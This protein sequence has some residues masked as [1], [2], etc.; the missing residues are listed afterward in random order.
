MITAVHALLYTRQASA[1]RAFL[2]DT[3]G[4]RYVDEGGGW[5]I[6]ALPPAELGV[7]PTDGQPAAELSLVCD[8]LAA[9]MA[10]LRAA[11][12]QFVGPVEERD[13]GSV[14]KVSIADGETIDLYQPK[15]ISPLTPPG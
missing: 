10:E 3:I 6:F 9:T 7:H 1:V 14:T 4:W 5:L 11:G 8:D 2:R 13:Y 15:H 12:V